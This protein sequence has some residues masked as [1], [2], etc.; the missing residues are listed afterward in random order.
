MAK[1]TPIQNNF[2]AGELSPRMYGR[3]DLP[4][5]ANGVQELKNFLI[6][7]QGG[8]FRRPGTKFIGEVKNSSQAA[9][10]IPFE[11]STTDRYIL[12]LS[13]G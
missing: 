9:R 11:F 8:A 10:L 12:E 5:Y 7:P 6:K 1:V 4:A 2:N 13:G 3:S